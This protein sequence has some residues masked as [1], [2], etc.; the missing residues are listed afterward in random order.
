MSTAAKCFKTL[1]RCASHPLNQH[2]PVERNPTKETV[3]WDNCRTFV[4]Q[5]VP[6]NNTDTFEIQQA[7]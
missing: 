5:K 2:T 7:T 4:V 3:L 6:H 1:P